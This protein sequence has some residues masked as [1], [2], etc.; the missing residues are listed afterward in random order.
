MSI[1]QRGDGLV[2]VGGRVRRARQ[3]GVGGLLSVTWA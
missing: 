3:R 2:V 1:T